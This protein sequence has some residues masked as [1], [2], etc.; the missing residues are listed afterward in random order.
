MII[1]ERVHVRDQ[2]WAVTIK[3]QNLLTATDSQS[4][5]QS[6]NKHKKPLKLRIFPLF[7]F[8]FM[9]VHKIT[10]IGFNCPKSLVFN[11]FY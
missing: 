1:V 4:C 10:S 5:R 9:K 3:T 11:L 8:Y 2:I 6:L 7:L